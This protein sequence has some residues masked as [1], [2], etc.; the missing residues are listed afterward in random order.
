MSHI[1]RFLVVLLH[2]GC[3][4]AV[5]AL[6]MHLWFSLEDPGFPA[7]ASGLLLILLLCPADLVLTLRLLRGD[8]L[9]RFPRALLHFWDLVLLLP[10][11]TAA[12]LGF[13]SGGSGAAFG[14][15]VVI[16]DLVLILERS[17][18][19]VKPVTIKPVPDPSS[20]AEGKE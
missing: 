16:S 13:V 9:G 17:A 8:A 18:A 7:A 14:S 3:T 20:D 1:K 10:L 19:Y 6:L 11:L 2:L 5:Q 4:A 15:A 12:F